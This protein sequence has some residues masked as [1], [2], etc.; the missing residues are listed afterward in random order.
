MQNYTTADHL[1]RVHWIQW[2]WSLQTHS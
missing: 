1:K 2:M